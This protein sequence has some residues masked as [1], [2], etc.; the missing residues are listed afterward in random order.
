MKVTCHIVVPHQDSFQL[1]KGF[2]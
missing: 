2:W 1:K